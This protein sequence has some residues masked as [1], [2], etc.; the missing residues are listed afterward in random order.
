MLQ[1]NHEAYY[2]FS[3]Y[4]ARFNMPGDTDQRMF[5]SF[6]VGPVHFISGK[7]IKVLAHSRLSN[8]AFSMLF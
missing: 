7:L 1:G 5:Y 3:N 4:K 8:R 6:N 2:N